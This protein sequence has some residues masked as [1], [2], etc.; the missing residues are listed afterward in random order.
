MDNVITV[1]IPAQV[2]GRSKG[3]E[4]RLCQVAASCTG[5]DKPI[6]EFTWT[7]TDY[8]TIE[9][10][11]ICLGCGHI[12]TSYQLLELEAA[13]QG[14]KFAERYRVYEDCDDCGQTHI[15]DDPACGWEDEEDDD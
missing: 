5:K 10:K 7:R 4:R 9:E 15:V 2:G 6:H 13:I 8:Q 1:A 3:K 14:Y 11:A 12:S